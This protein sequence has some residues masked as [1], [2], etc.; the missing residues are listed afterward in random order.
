MG[1]RHECRYFTKPW[2]GH[3]RCTY[4]N[5]LY[6]HVG[7]RWVRS[8]TA[9]AFADKWLPA[10][11]GTNPKTLMQIDVA[12]PFEWNCYESWNI[13][14]RVRFMFPERPTQL[15]TRIDVMSGWESKWHEDFA[16]VDFEAEKFYAER[17]G[18]P[19]SIGDNTY[20]EMRRIIQA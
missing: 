6:L 18:K 14:F 13:V 9:R 15:A 17:T 5:Q 7:G 19:F 12:F 3:K 2:R 11:S 16:Q 10:I 1:K 4:C 8:M 20:P